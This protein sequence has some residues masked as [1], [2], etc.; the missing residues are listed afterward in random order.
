MQAGDVTFPL[1]PAGVANRVQ[2][3]VFRTTNRS[4]PVATMIGPI[5][6]VNTVDIGATATAEASPANAATCVK[7]FTI[8]D[9]WTENSNPVWTTDSTYDRY[10]NHGNLLP[11]A[12]AYIPAGQPGYTGYSA[13]ADK[14]LS[15]LIRAGTGNNIAPSFYWS[16]AMPGG[17]GGDFYRDNIA[18][19]NT[20]L[21]HYGDGN[22]AGARQHGWAHQPGHR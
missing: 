12:D 8:P 5:F 22:D 18:H 16:W 19:C 4:N 6:G 3:N 13:D 11:N 15:L 14:G 2:V 7:P 1:G 10:D 9:R 20:T 17:T 21:M